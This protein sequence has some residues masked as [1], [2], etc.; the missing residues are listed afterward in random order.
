M[1]I[2]P[3]CGSCRAPSKD[4]VLCAGCTSDLAA[5]LATIASL[6]PDLDDAVGCQLVRG[7]GGKRADENP[8]PVDPGAMDVRDAVRNVLGGWVRVIMESR[9]S[10]R[11]AWPGDLIAVM[12]RWLHARTGLLRQHEA[13]ASIHREVLEARRAVVVAVDRRPDRV[14]AGPCPDCGAD[15]LGDPGASVITCRCCGGRHEAGE[16][17]GAMREALEDQLG[18][19]SWCAAVATATGVPLSENTVKSWA[20]R[21]RLAPKGERRSPLDTRPHKVYRLGDVLKLAAQRPARG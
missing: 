21:E 18:S 20:Q 15:L 3:Q 13:A 1:T 16:R 10:P 6:A 7:G 11:A 8:L 17:L 19:V 14:Y 12:A 5:A 9:P 2:G 4:A